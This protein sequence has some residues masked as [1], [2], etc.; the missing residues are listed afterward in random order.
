MEVR[1]E[2][3]GR[4]RVGVVPVCGVARQPLVSE[5]LEH[6]RG[7]RG[8][9]DILHRGDAVIDRQAFDDRARIVEERCRGVGPAVDDLVRQ[10]PQ[11]GQP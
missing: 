3:A 11:P 9:A 2:A 7:R 1:R 8:A 10:R 5:A 6:T 4:V